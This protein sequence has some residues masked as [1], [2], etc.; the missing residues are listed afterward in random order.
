[1][2]KSINLQLIGISSIVVLIDQFTKYIARN[3]LS[4]RSLHILGNFVSLTFVKNEGAVFGI[5]QGARLFLVI[6]SV[7]SLAAIAF[8]INRYQL[9]KPFL[10]AV[11]LIVGGIAGNLLDRI[12]VGYIT[13]FISISKWPVFNIA[14][15]AIDVGVL[16][17]IVLVLRGKNAFES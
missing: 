11:G 3:F 14:D 15:S 12:F 8:V 13:D 10:V 4:G 9:A 6:L 17:F 7:L 5:L 16:I 1:M 2:E